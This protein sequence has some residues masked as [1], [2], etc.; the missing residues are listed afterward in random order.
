MERLREIN[1]KAFDGELKLVDTI[2]ISLLYFVVAC[3]ALILVKNTFSLSEVV[4]NS[5]GVF[6]VVPTIV[7]GFV[8]I[9][10]CANKM[11]NPNDKIIKAAIVL[12]I[13]SLVFA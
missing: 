9:W 11:K 2:L 4:F 8:S 1:T 3:L 6:V 13:A 5:I 7:F 12:S 10:R